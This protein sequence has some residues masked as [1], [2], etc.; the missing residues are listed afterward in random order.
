MALSIVAVTTIFYVFSRHGLLN[1]LET[2]SQLIDTEAGPIE[3]RIVGDSGPVI[4]YFHGT[5]GGYD[6]PVKAYPGTRMLVPSR[7]GYL[8]TSLEVGRSPAEQA[9]ALSALLDALHIESVV[10]YGVSGG[11]PSAISFAAHYPDRTLG[12]ISVSTISQPVDVPDDLK[13]PFPLQSDLV[14]WAAFS[15]LTRI[16]GP[17]QTVRTIVPDPDNQQLILADPGNADQLVNL[18]WSLWP[19]SL[20]EAGWKNDNRYFETM[21]LPSREITVPTLILHGTEDFNAPFS[22]SEQLAQQI[23]GSQLHAVQG[24]DHMMIFSHRQ[25]IR[26]AIVNFLQS[27]GV[28]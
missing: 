12:L 22:N 17:D 7:P 25:E 4:L 21:D 5:P 2:G 24:G 3:Y 14:S 9:K 6:A 23:P 1:A 27:I 28:E 20:R 16:A 19:F 13:P 15:L 18:I 26:S 11:G 10:A 8:R